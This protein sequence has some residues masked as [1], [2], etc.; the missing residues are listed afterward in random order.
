LSCRSAP[1]GDVGYFDEQGELFLTGRVDDMIITGGENV[2][3]IE[4]E[5][6]LSLHPDVAEAIVIGRPDE[7]LGQRITACIVAKQAVRAS[8][9]DAHCRTLGLPGYRC[10]KDY[11]FV[12]RIPKSPVGKILRRML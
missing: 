10:P 12:D 6:V 2:M 5:S 3:P 11:E 8:A 4:I 9:L 7:R 1:T